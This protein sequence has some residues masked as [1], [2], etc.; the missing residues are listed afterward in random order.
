M[1]NVVESQR[2]LWVHSVLG[3]W[4]ETA[5]R[6]CLSLGIW[7]K[8][9]L[10]QGHYWNSHQV[11]AETKA[12]VASI[13]PASRGGEVHVHSCSEPSS[14]PVMQLSVD[15]DQK[16]QNKQAHTAQQLHSLHQPSLLLYQYKTHRS[17]NVIIS[18]KE[19]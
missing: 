4:A 6:H 18:I 19:K 1:T 12:V 7:N 2:S 13:Q 11:P 10:N 5:H 8:V 16:P 15:G 9:H 14:S 3:L 17:E